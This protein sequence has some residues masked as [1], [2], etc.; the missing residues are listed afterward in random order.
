MVAMARSAIIELSR[1]HICC[2]MLWL[3]QPQL[4]RCVFAVQ[5]STKLLCDRLTLFA[6][7]ASVLCCCVLL[8]SL[9]PSLAAAGPASSAAGGSGRV[10]VIKVPI[11]PDTPY[12]EVEAVLQDEPAWQVCVGVCS[13]KSVM[14][15]CIA[16]VL[17]TR[18]C[19]CASARIQ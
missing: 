3:S 6:S 17:G 16:S 14:S 12:S 1:Q 7:A 4:V 11:D 18:V 8:V 19:V 13:M 15:L 2:H 10:S 5:N 9:S